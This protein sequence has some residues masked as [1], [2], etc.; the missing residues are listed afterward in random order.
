[1]QISKAVELR[2]GNKITIFGPVDKK[3][4]LVFEVAEKP[5]I[6]K[7]PRGPFARITAYD[8]HGRTRIFS[9]DEVEYKEVC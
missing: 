5:A 3:D 7:S 1:M 6:M 4:D 2:K 8:R 9:H